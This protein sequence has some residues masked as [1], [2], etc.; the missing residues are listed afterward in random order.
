MKRAWPYMRAEGQGQRGQTD[1][2][3][4][5]LET[6]RGRKREGEDGGGWRAKE[7]ESGSMDVARDL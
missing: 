7:G 4:S 6:H 3:V 1:R 5:C 2:F